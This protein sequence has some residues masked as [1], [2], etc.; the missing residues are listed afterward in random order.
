MVKTAA[1]RRGGPVLATQASPCGRPTAKAPW[2]LAQVA[3]GSLSRMLRK[4]QPMEVLFLHEPTNKARGRPGLAL[5]KA[6]QTSRP[7]D[8]CLLAIAHGRRNDGKHKV[9]ARCALAAGQA[10]WRT[11]CPP[12][13]TLGCTDW[14]ARVPPTPQ[15]RGVALVSVA[16]EPQRLARGAPDCR[17]SPAHG[18]L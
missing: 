15:C 10:T 1:P 16:A 5:P 4:V 9:Y 6:E 3:V 14:P 7:G 13:P 11:T 8:Y 18:N 12:P 17:Q 2:A